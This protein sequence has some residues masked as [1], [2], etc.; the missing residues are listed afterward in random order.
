M[1]DTT[2]VTT[3]GVNKKLWEKAKVE[4]IRKHTTLGNIINEE[5][6]DRY[7]PKEGEG[8]AKNGD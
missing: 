5:L 8:D 7:A 6:A 2:K 4:C 3:R 1:P